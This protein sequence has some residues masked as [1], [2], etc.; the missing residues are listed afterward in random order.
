LTAADIVLTLGASVIAA[1]SVVAGHWLARKSA[2]DVGTRWSVDRQDAEK[3]WARERSYALLDQAL[4]RALSP[5]DETT[6]AVGRALLL[7]LLRSKIIQEEDIEIVRE[8]V[9][10]LMPEF[11]GSA[12]QGIEVV[13]ERS[14]V[15]NGE[16][17]S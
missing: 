10:A 17:A 11:H 2:K 4:T 15:D 13:V 6:R 5:T 3:R 7:A 1:L 16:E 8:V 14:P 9:G 12:G